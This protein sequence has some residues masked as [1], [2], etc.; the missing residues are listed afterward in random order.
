MRDICSDLEIGRSNGGVLLILEH[1]LDSVQNGVCVK[2]RGADP[3]EV[4]ADQELHIFCV[5]SKPARV[6]EAGAKVRRNGW[7]ESPR[8]DERACQDARGCRA[9]HG[10]TFDTR[11]PYSGY[12]GFAPNDRACSGPVSQCYRSPAAGICRDFEFDCGGNNWPWVVCDSSH[13]LS[14]EYCPMLD[15]EYVPAEN[16]LSQP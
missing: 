9:N 8:F 5:G 11:T 1:S 2:I 7:Q 4:M 14:R 6:G 13:D 15:L 10:A 16:P 12:I 3:A